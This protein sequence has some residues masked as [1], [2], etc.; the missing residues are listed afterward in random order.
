M[1]YPK[2]FE[3]GYIGRLKIKNRAVMSPMHTLLAEPDGT[4]GERMIRYYEERAKGGIGLIINEAT[5]IDDVFSSS[6]SC[7]LSMV[8][9]Y[10]TIQAERLTEAVHKHGAKIFAQLHHGGATSDPKYCKSGEL[11][12]IS[13]IPAA[14]GRPVPRKMTTEEIRVIIDKFVSAA[15]RCKMAGY[16]GVELHG[17]HGYL[18]AET[19][20]PYYNN[21][22]DEYGGSF[23]KRMRMIT[24]IIHGI[25]GA[26]GSNF[27]ISVR[28]CGDEMTPWLDGMMDL[29]YGLQIAKYL[30]AQ[31][32]DCINISNGSAANPN[33]N[34]EPYS[35]RPGWKKHVAKAYKEHLR[36]PVIATNTIKDPA[37]AESLLE[38]G[39]CDFVALGRSQVADPEFVKKA[40]EGR[41]KEIRQ[42]IGCMY[43]RERVIQNGMPIEC[44]V[45]PRVGCE[46]IYTD[47]NING[48]E[49]PVAVIGAGPAGMEA[50]KLLADRGFAVTLYEKEDKLGGWLNLADKPRFKDNIQDLINTMEMELKKR[51]V[52]IKLGVEAT[53]EMVKEDIAPVGVFLA[54]GAEW[55]VPPIKGVE[56]AIVCTPEDVILKKVPFGKR[57]VVIGCGI[58]G[59]ECAEMLL[60]SGVQVTMVD[61]LDQIG[62]GVYPVIVNDVMARVKE[63]QPEILLQHRLLEITDD[64]ALLENMMTGKQVAVPADTV[65]LSLGSAPI[66]GMTERFE[67]SFDNV[68]VIGSADKDGRIHDA[69]KQGYLRSYVFE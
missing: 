63:R 33:A 47:P 27:P 14:P 11:V 19:F 46:Y 4:P 34:C 15:V 65:C 62:K 58:T 24:E 28:I 2:F 25:R 45:N 49:R 36:I 17:A 1:R 22:T 39:V 57:A 21:R 23:E 37:F 16:D 43:C 60:D 40:K 12:A 30:E 55:I 9:D 56:K 68:V 51:N 64:G 38:E 59:I 26:L 44:S 61:M 29:D 5:R 41:E 6:G 31:G 13:E 67:K 66:K 8:Y 7:Q 54:T 52:A 53:P 3:E 35:Y 69:T 32:I 50:A 10:C 18:L 48:D 20:S 42:C